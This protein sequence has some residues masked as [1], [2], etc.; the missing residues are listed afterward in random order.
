MIQIKIDLS[1]RSFVQGESFVESGGVCWWMGRT[2][3]GNHPE[4]YRESGNAA[5]AKLNTYQA[6]WYGLKLRLT[7]S[8]S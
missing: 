2:I 6:D 4:C 8:S 3:I 5:C 7:L 1:K